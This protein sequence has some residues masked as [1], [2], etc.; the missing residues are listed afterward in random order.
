METKHTSPNTK[1][2]NCD[3]QPCFEVLV[4]RHRHVDAERYW[5]GYLHTYFD[6][7]GFECPKR[8]TGNEAERGKPQFNRGW[9]KL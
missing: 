5:C 9:R 2:T 4:R 7:E 6:P 3:G 8:E 1:G